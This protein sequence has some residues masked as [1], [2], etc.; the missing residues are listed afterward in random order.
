MSE[1]IVVGIGEYKVAKGTGIIKSYSLG[2]CVGVALYDQV[3]K[4]GGLSHIMLANSMCTTDKNSMRSPFKYADIGVRMM[5]HDMVERGAN[6]RILNAKIAGGACMFVSAL[7]DPIFD[8]GKRNVEAVKKVLAEE[9]I[10]LVGEDCGK[11]YG[12]TLE[13]DVE[14]GRLSVKGLK[15]GILIL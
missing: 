9:R 13:F 14:T 11:N 8:V 1:V 12:R 6:R 3:S 2:S 7:K 15:S 10:S 5:I 4:I